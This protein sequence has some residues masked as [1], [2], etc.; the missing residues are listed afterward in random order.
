MD[1]NLNVEPTGALGACGSVYVDI[2]AVLDSEML[3][4]LRRHVDVSVCDDTALGEL[5]DALRT[6]DRYRS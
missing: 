2:V 4:V 6:D 5:D 1:A 3:A